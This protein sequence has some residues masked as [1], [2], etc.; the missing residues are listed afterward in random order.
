VSRAVQEILQGE[1]TGG[2]R[3]PIGRP[4]VGRQLL[5]SRPR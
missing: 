5:A 3:H 2:T 1:V 4:E